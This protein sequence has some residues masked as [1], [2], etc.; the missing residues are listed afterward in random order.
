M[1]KYR[2][3]KIFLYIITVFILLNSVIFAG[4][5]AATPAS[6]ATQREEEL[7]RRE[8][9]LR[10]REAELRQREQRIEG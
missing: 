2:N 4:N 8:E 10:Q 6:P 7:R 1:K 9:A 3:L 5:I